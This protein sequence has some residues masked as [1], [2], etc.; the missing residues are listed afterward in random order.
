MLNQPP[1]PRVGINHP[2][3][4]D[5]VT[6]DRKA[7]AY[8]LVVIQRGPWDGSHEQLLKLQAKLN[9]YMTFAL[10]GEMYRR[11]PESEGKQ[12]IIRLDLDHPPDEKTR[13]T[14]E[15]LRAAIEA[16]DVG[17]ELHVEG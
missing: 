5:L 9:S 3:V 14:L 4:I 2:G 16:E 11:Y 10:D 1:P 15:K 6:H 7:D 8:R 12:V 17:F 13:A